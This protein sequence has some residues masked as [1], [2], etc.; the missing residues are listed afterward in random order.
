MAAAIPLAGAALLIAILEA[1][2]LAILIV[3]LIIVVVA[4]IY[5]LATVAIPWVID[6]VAEAWQT[7]TRTIEETYERVK[8]KVRD[9]AR[10]IDR[11][12]NKLKTHRVYQ[13]LMV[14]PGRYPRRNRGFGWNGFHNFPTDSSGNP[15]FKYGITIMA[16]I[17]ARYSGDPIIRPLLSSGRVRGIF[18]TPKC[19]VLQARAT[20]S[21]LLLAYHTAH[22]LFPPGNSKFG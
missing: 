4:V 8:T 13:L 2:L 21:S 16:T 15:T 3:V 22:G 17:N 7:M 18:L 19:F 1:L 6:R 11:A 10:E 9:W 12:T 14:T 20:E 5:W